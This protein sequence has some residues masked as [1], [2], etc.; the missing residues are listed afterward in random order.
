MVP[1]LSPSVRLPHPDSCNVFYLWKI[2]TEPAGDPVFDPCDLFL[3][4]DTEVRQVSDLRIDPGWNIWI[5]ESSFIYQTCNCFWIF[6][7]IL[8]RIIVIQFFG[9]LDMMR[10]YMYR[11]HPLS[12]QYA[13]KVQPVVAGWFHPWNHLFHFMFLC[14]I[15][16]P[17]FE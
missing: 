16:H 11:P 12:L 2:D 17:G 9:F 1:V 7:V 10:I 5:R 8:I 6:T 3:C 4:L 15:I 14:Y 13:S